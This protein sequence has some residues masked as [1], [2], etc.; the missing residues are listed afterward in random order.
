M[1]KAIYRGKL[2]KKGGG[3]WT[4]YRLKGGGGLGEKA[5]AGIFEGG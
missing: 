1:K 5:G 4:V 3:A 2:P